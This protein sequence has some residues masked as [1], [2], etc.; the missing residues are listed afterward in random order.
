[1]LFHAFSRRLADFYI[2]VYPPHPWI[3]IFRAMG[4][5]WRDNIIARMCMQAGATHFAVYC[6]C[7]QK[8]C[9]GGHMG[10]PATQNDDSSS[11]EEQ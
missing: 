5:K 10:S 9:K 3:T 1:V 8:S 7:V 6:T 2:R 4:Q 11:K